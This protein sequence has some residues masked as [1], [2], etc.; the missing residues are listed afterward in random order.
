MPLDPTISSID[1]RRLLPFVSKPAAMSDT[2]VVE[3]LDEKLASATLVEPREM[4]PTVVTMNSRVVLSSPGW[5]GA[6]EYR[7]VY[8]TT[9][10]CPEGEVAVL[11]ALGV[12][13][14]AA[15]TGT[16]L[17]VGKGA[18]ARVIDVIA[19]SYQPEAAGDWHL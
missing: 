11:S 15:R 16:R 4:P 13:L 17:N 6:R 9:G 8:P 1:F 2:C 5:A 14:L 18:A 19:I 7:L 12:E 3:S 10:P